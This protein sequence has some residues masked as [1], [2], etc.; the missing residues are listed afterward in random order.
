M[1]TGKILLCIKELEKG[2]VLNFRPSTCLSLIWKILTDALAGEL[3]RHLQEKN[4]LPC[5]Q[6]GRRK[7]SRDTKD[8]LLVDKMII[9]DSKIRFTSLGVAWIDYRQAYEYG[10]T[11]KRVVLFFKRGKV[12]NREGVVMPDGQIEKWIEEVCVYKYFGI[13]EVDRLIQEE[14]KEQ[15][16]KEYISRMSNIWDEV[17]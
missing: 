6:K 4:L 3:Y 10:T 15:T 7:G 13:L 14:M 12:F 5:V 8:Q 2:N 9:K 16:R 1:V 17:F 11:L